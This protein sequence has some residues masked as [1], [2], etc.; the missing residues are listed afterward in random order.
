MTASVALESTIYAFGLPEEEAFLLGESLESIV[1]SEG[2]VPVPIA[3]IDGAPRYGF[4]RATLRAVCRGTGFIKVNSRDLGAMAALKK[5][6]AT[7]VSGTCAL[8]AQRGIRVFATGGIG[9]VHR[10]AEKSFDESLD[11]Q[12]LQKY[13]VAVVSAGA[14]AILDLPKT[15]ERL[16]T[17]G[18]PVWGY[19]TQEFP[20]FYTR[21]RALKLEWSFT[22]PETLAEALQEHWRHHPHLGVLICN[23]IP[24]AD[25][26]NQEQVQ[27]WLNLALEEARNQSI[28]GKA[29]TPF[30]LKDLSER[31]QGATV[32]ANLSL[33]KNNALLAAKIAVALEKLTLS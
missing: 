7:T 13:P 25:A 4:D 5:N 2:A 10:G 11:L 33:I 23:P 21:G 19:Q 30:L 32:G 8:A 29:L 3:V 14:K 15:L 20:E 1:T 24:Q 31:S 26:L 16:E 22:N 9:G 12:A 18:V 17:L 28:Q 27:K 6:G